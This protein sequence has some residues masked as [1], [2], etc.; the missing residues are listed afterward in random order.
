MFLIVCVLF[1]GK[2]FCSH[3]QSFKNLVELL[4]IYTLRVFSDCSLLWFRSFGALWGIW[5][6]DTSAVCLLCG[7]LFYSFIGCDG[8]RVL[9]YNRV[10]WRTSPVCLFSHIYTIYTFNLIGFHYSNYLSLG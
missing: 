2:G 1:K 7:I 10:L 9:F 3:V 8:F 4:E 5:C 6:D